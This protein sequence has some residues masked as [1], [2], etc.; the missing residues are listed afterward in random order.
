MPAKSLIDARS[1]DTLR[2]DAY[3]HGAQKLHQ[4]NIVGSAFLLNAKPAWEVLGFSE[5]WAHDFQ[6]EVETKFT[7]WA[8]SPANWPDASR[9]KTLT[10]MVR[11]AVAVFLAGGEVLA[12]AEWLRHSRGPMRTAIQLIDADRLSNPFRELDSQTTRAGIR[13]DRYGAPLGYHI[14]EAHPSDF[15]NPDVMT[16][17]YVPARKPWGRV[18]VIHIVE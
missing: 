16:W 4:D 11:L 12:S 9:T 1:R 5:E 7:L 17:K 18:Q 8:E 3:V 10:D 13:R 14:R 6:K 2:N 15:M